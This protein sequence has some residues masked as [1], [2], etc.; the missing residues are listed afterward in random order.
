MQELTAN[1]LPCLIVCYTRWSIFSLPLVSFSMH[2]LQ[3]VTFCDEIEFEGLTFEDFI[4]NGDGNPSYAGGSEIMSRCLFIC[5]PLF[6]LGTVLVEYVTRGSLV[7]FN[8]CETEGKHGTSVFGF[9]GVEAD[10]LFWDGALIVNCIV[11]ELF[12]EW[13]WEVR[14]FARD[15]DVLI[16]Y[17]HEAEVPASRIKVLDKKIFGGLL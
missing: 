5:S 9:F 16:K 4:S 17:I 11:Y 6:A 3:F 14:K 15:H 2:S 7:I 13:Y 10:V 1:V 8:I 12:G